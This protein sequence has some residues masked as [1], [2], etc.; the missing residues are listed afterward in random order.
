MTK[1]RDCYV[2]LDE[3]PYYH[4]VSRCVRKA[5][6]CGEDH[7][8]GDNF[9]YRRGW[10]EAR[11]LE[12][13]QIFCIDIC[14]YAVMSNHY[15]VVLYVDRN[16]AK[17]L[18]NLEVV[19]RWHQLFKGSPLTQKLLRT[20][21]LD[22][23]EWDVVYEQIELWRSR[24]MDISWFMRCAN[25]PIAREA[26]REDNC[27]G[28]FW[29]GRF[30]SQALL[31]EQA[32]MACMAYVDLN[33]V[34]AKMAN[35]PEQSDFTSARVRA[36]QARSVA[37][38]LHNPNHINHQ[39]KSLMPFAGRPR[40]NMPKG[41]PFQLRSY[42]ELLDWTGRQIRPNKRG[43]ISQAEPEILAR[44]GIDSVA[45]LV[46]CCHFESRFKAIV[47]CYMHLKHSCKELGH[48]RC[49]GAGNCKLCF[50]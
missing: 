26:N 37:R 32:L 5:F 48:S 31:D 6:L 43:A 45:W 12:L 25:E 21:E 18:T 11:I 30:K 36:K 13:A 34:R 1:R 28:R 44:L 7:Q 41:L 39:L 15:H 4:C 19:E 33:P 47:G 46:S 3:T 10:I 38:K 20:G 22:A 14:T 42:L 16:Q 35:T 8:T 27:T 40:K 17:S 24:L 29:E 50:G 23:A 49:A 2:S 9:E